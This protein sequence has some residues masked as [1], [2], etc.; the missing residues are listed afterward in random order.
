MRCVP[1]NRRAATWRGI[2]SVYARVERK[3]TKESRTLTVQHRGRSCNDDNADGNVRSTSR[4]DELKSRVLH[5]TPRRRYPP[6][7]RSVES[8]EG[9]LK[10]NK[11]RFV[12][13]R[14]TTNAANSKRT[15][16][17]LPARV[18]RYAPMFSVLRG[19]KKKLA[20]CGQHGRA[21]GDS[22][23]ED[24]SFRGEYSTLAA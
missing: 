10:S 2:A 23:G 9:N 5:S 11:P 20:R 22:R 7:S 19:R 13:A 8:V 17:T 12:R 6:R 4:K 18:R 3:T 14:M 16:R 15:R 21:L 24:S 1:R